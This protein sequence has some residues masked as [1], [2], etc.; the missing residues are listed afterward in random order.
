MSPRPP[1][2]AP[3]YWLLLVF[4]ALLLSPPAWATIAIVCVGIGGIALPGLRALP[5][6]RGLSRASERD[7]REAAA[8]GTVLG[9]ERTG[10]Q[11]VLSDRQ[12]S[13]HDADSRR[14][15]G[16]KVDDD[17]VDPHRS[18]APRPTGRGHR[19]EGLTGVRPRARRAAAA[20]AG[21]PFRLWTPDGPGHWNPLAH[22]NATELKDKLIATERFTEPHYQRAA[23][24]YV[25]IALQVL[26]QANPER[27]ATLDAVVEVMDPARL[28]GAE[29]RPAPRPGRAP[30]RLPVDADAGS[31]Q[32]GAR[33][34]DAAGD[35][36]RVALGRVP[37][38]ARPAS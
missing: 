12:L 21:R 28:A 9:A 7:R 24:R 17:A 13:A 3:R 37:V 15:R 16:G 36:Q 35:P 18:R 8:H 20:A 32:R 6:L 23:E 30:A 14:Q 27:P 2:R 19:H 38:A 31:A 1:T 26:H 33:A 10:R 22:G 29:S 4:G 34:G 5:A 11:V 25:Q